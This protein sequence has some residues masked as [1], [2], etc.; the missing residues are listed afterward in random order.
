[1]PAYATAGGA[2][3]EWTEPDLPVGGARKRWTEAYV[4]VG[5]ARKQWFSRGR[6]YV[7]G[8]L[9]GSSDQ[10]I[11][12]VRVSGNNV[13]FAPVADVSNTNATYRKMLPIDENTFI[14]DGSAT[15]ALCEVSG[16]SVTVTLLTESGSPVTSGDAA[17]TIAGRHFMLPNP[18]TQSSSL[19][20]VT[21]NAD[22]DTLFYTARSYSTRQESIDNQIGGGGA[23]T[24][25]GK[26]YRMGGSGI[27]EVYIS[28]TNTLAFRNLKTWLDRPSQFNIEAAFGW[29][30]R[31][32]VIAGTSGSGAGKVHAATEE[33][34]GW[35]LVEL[36]EMPDFGVGWG[37]CALI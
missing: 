37:A 16:S 18:V 36:G 20:E 17:A 32:I 9:E 21:L 3:K 25:N 19:R 5:G 15:A 28:I 22:R 8:F 12:S 10:R 29:G 24:V 23:A 11:Y 27:A 34:S 31:L 30:D 26:T 13:S 7:V 2:R 4:T 35:R 6:A 33:G 14:I 1:M